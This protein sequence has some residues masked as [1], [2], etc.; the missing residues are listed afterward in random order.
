MRISQLEER[1]NFLKPLELGNGA[2]VF[3]E[4][5]AGDSIYFISSGRIRISKRLYNPDEKGLAPEE[6]DL[7]LLGPG[8][9]FGE[10]ALTGENKRSAQARADG[11]TVIFELNL[12]DLTQWIRSR[13]Q[14]ALGFFALLV[15]V[16]SKRLRH[17][18][19]ELTMLFDLSNLFLEET[20]S[21]NQLL[22]SPLAF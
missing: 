9:C 4:G 5:S 1:G 21:S 11:A 18:S 13:P 8:D 14:L 6:K 10:M 7:A 2:V 22:T 15:E 17:T 12:K 19:N 16:Q 20:S 3:E